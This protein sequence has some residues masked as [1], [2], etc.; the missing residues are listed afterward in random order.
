MSVSRRFKRAVVAQSSDN[1]EYVRQVHEIP[2]PS[3]C[4][5][6]PGVYE[7]PRGKRGKWTTSKAGKHIIELQTMNDVSEKLKA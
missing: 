7:L 2:V 4:G 5:S 1:Q 3:E 6:L